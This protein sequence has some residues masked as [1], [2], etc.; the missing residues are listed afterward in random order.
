LAAAGLDPA[1]TAA[2]I[3]AAAD[4][5]TY[6]NRHGVIRHAGFYMG[7]KYF[8]FYKSYDMIKK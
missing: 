6:K 8:L 1:G 2:E 5:K 3:T 7:R 4:G